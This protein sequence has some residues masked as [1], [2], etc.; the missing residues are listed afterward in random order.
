MKV[1]VSFVGTG[2]SVGGARACPKG[3]VQNCMGH[4]R[5]P[6]NR[7]PD[8]HGSEKMPKIPL[9]PRK[10]YIDR[11]NVQAVPYPEARSLAIF[12]TYMSVHIVNVT[13]K[14]ELFGRNPIDFTSTR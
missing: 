8:M 9:F 11:I 6:S 12:P 2:K 5:V 3:D 10:V 7:L 1:P 14:R 4:S 13:D